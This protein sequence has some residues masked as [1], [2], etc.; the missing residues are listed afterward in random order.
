MVTVVSDRSTA[1]PGHRR[2]LK[3]NGGSPMKR[4]SGQRIES[5]ANARERRLHGFLSNKKK[6]GA[7]GQFTLRPLASPCI[8]AGRVRHL[9]GVL[10]GIKLRPAPRRIA[11]QTPES[12]RGRR[13]ALP[14]L[15]C[16][17][18]RDLSDRPNPDS[19]WRVAPSVRPRARAIVAI[20]VLRRASP[21]SSRTSLSVHARRFVALLVMSFPF[22]RNLNARC[23]FNKNAR[24]Q[25]VV[26]MK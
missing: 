23:A 19:F 6:T 20:G 14:A 10:T 11:R 3:A 17:A 22:V 25:P 13:L 2:W 4:P 24:Y 15:L 16:C 9:T 8:G 12:Q 21:L 5:P 18:R 26:K 1:A 7:G